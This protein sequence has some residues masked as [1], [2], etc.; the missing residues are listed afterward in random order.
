MGSKI[1]RVQRG[2]LLVLALLVAWFAYARVTADP[3]GYCATQQRVIPNEEFIVDFLDAKIKSGQLKL[4]PSESTG[5][6]YLRN[7]PGC[8]HVDRSRLGEFRRQGLMNVLFG[9]ETYAIGITYE[10]SDAFKEKLN[11]PPAS[12]RNDRGALIAV[13]RCGRVLDVSEE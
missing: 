7:H 1:E 12:N 10:V 2:A 6:D 9:D 11:I 8:C 4:G 3:P 13:N 5:R